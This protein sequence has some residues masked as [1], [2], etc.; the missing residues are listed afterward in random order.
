MSFSFYRL[1]S[2]VLVIAA[3]GLI[4]TSSPASSDTLTQTPTCGIVNLGSTRVA[5]A[6]KSFDCFTAAFQRCDQVSLRAT[7]SEA[8]A[9]VTWTF[10]TLNAGRGCA[11][12]E[13]VE[14]SAGGTKTTDSYL[15]NAVSNEKDGLHFNDCGPKGSVALQANER[16]SSVLQPLSQQ[17]NSSKS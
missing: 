14:R 1:C 5:D 10:I 13:T 15:C 8:D 3:L 9:A 2:M 17:S 16:F 4:S 11:I 12:S 6:N 7:G